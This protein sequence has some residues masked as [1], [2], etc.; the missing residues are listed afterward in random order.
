MFISNINNH[1]A[2][3]G[4]FVIAKQSKN[5]KKPSFKAQPW[6]IDIGSLEYASKISGKEAVNIFEKFKLGNYLDLDGGANT[7]I[8]SFIR[9]N[10]LSFLDKVKDWADKNYFVQFYKSLTGFPNLWKVADNIKEQ[11]KSAVRASESALKLKCEPNDARYYDILDFGYDGVSSVA[12]NKALPGSD[13]DKAFIILKGAGSYDYGQMYM[14]ENIVNNFRAELWHNTDQRILSYNHDLDS[15]PKIYTEEQIDL[16][17]GSIKSKVGLSKFGQ[18]TPFG[19]IEA[20]A[21]TILSSDHPP[22]EYNN[23]YVDANRY[24]IKLCKKFPKRNSWTLDINNPSRENIYN[25]CFVLEALKWGEHFKDNYFNYYVDSSEAARHLN[26]SQIYSLKNS[27][28]YKKKY[29]QREKLEK[30]FD[31]WDIDKQFRFIKNLIYSSCGE[32]T[33]DFPEYFKSSEA[34]K[35]NE[36]MKAVDL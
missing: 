13:L 5:N 3:I 23:N 12:K 20:F 14:D 15:F 29:V 2:N 19:I 36:L 30:E 16:L 25:F 28:G 21:R 22:E 1:S 17:I 31:S 18:A 34:S 35:F 8:N 4:N 33:G 10:N 26:V 27:A 6:K 11:F 7:S 32:N 9:K 24:F